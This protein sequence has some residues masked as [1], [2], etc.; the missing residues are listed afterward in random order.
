M[1]STR[2]KAGLPA[3]FLLPP[4]PPSGTHSGLG[5]RPG[6]ELARDSEGGNGSEQ[7]FQSG[8]GHL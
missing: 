1:I 3:F 2:K 8:L 5:T 6:P 4:T 7:E